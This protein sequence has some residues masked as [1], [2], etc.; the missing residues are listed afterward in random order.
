MQNRKDVREDHWGEICIQKL[1]P[2][3]A[4]VGGQIWRRF[5]KKLAEKEVSPAGSIGSID[6]W[7]NF[8]E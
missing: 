1:K 2:H 7:S 4:D 3:L 6:G 8:C 5:H